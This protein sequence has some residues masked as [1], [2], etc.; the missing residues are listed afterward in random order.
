MPKNSVVPRWLRLAAPAPVA[1]IIGSV[2]RSVVSA[3]IRRARRRSPAAAPAA[4]TMENPSFSCLSFA[5]STSRMA[6]FEASPT[7]STRPS[8]A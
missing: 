4:S 3:V 7:R 8:C 6:F 1:S 2:P 5:N